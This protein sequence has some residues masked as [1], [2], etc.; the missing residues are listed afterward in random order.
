MFRPVFWVLRR[1]FWFG[2]GAS[3]GF[4]GAMWIRARL[5]RAVTRYAP[6]RVTSDVASGARRVG[7]E[8]RTAVSEGRE[9]MHSRE[10][11]LR[12]ELAPG[13]R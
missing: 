7:T 12:R 10:A 2:T 3:V 5:R 11:E 4:G 13:R 9:A 1:V 6:E 8:I